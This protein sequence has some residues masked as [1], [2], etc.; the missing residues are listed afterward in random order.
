LARKLAITE[1]KKTLAQKEKDAKQAL[2][3]EDG[4]S[5]IGRDK[6]RKRDGEI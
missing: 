3:R 5:K 2:G 6:E 4:Q 1:A